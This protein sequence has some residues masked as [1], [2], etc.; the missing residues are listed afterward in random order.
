MEKAGRCAAAVA[1]A[2]AARRSSTLRVVVVVV[3][4]VAADA[5]RRCAV[6]VVAAVPDE[7]LAAPRVGGRLAAPLLAVEEDCA[8][9]GRSTVADDSVVAEGGLVADGGLDG[10]FF[11]VLVAV[12][13]ADDE[14][15]TIDA[16]LLRIWPRTG[17]ARTGAAAVDAAAADAPAADRVRDIWLNVGAVADEGPPDD[18]GLPLDEVGRPLLD[19]G[20]RCVV[21]PLPAAAPGPDN[22][23]CE[24]DDEGGFV[25]GLAEAAIDDDATVEDEEAASGRRNLADDRPPVA[26]GGRGFWP[27]RVVVVPAGSLVG[28]RLGD[29]PRAPAS[30][31]CPA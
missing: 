16:D 31:A 29:E 23:R 7:A 4:V 18:V 14:L 3:D 25:N 8:D 28:R 10:G 20:L 11:A 5:F 26:D 9:G 30:V 1:A 6:D 15:D 21:A 27:I 24:R 19:V 12:V 13:A 2:A 22:I 17:A